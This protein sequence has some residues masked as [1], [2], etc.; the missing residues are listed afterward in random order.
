MERTRGI[1][2]RDWWALLL[3]GLVAIGFSVLALARPGP[4][5]VALVILFGAY[6]L[7]DGVVALV[8]AGR[9]AGRDES[10]WLRALEGVLGIALGLFTLL[11]PGHALAIAVVLIALWALCTGVLELIEATSLRREIRGEWILTLSGLVRLAF[12]IL[13]LTRPH[14]GVLTLLWIAAA[15]ALFDGILLVGLSFRIRRYTTKRE[16]VATGGMTPQPT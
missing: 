2:A 1:L 14:A 11:M 6:A 4:T 15:Y 16:R 5:L 9:A 8:G 3:R 13:L 12:G 7:G 10:W